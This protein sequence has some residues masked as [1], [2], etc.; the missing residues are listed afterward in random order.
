MEVEMRLDVAK[1]S[2]LYG[3]LVGCL[4]EEARGLNTIEYK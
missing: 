3:W 4:F 1:C 2:K